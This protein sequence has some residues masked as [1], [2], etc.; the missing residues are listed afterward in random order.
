MNLHEAIQGTYDGKHPVEVVNYVGNN[1]DRFAQ[2]VQVF[3]GDNVRATHYGSHVINALLE[4]HPELI[5][6]HLPHFIKLLS[7][8]VNDTIKRSIVRT[9]S[10]IEL[11]EDTFGEVYENCTI[12]LNNPKE[13]VAIRVF[14][15]TVMFNICKHYPE[16]GHE[17]KEMVILAMDNSDKPAIQSRG[18]RTLKGLD[19][20][21]NEV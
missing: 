6:P 19:K 1:K 8:P 3:L 7:Q 21:L 20:L 9:F 5:S 12:L 18:K 13:A 4:K 2:L 14:S 10:F 11:P 17:L 16:L 15:M